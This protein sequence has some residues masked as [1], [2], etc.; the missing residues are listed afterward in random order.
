MAAS[1]GL[2]DAQWAHLRKVAR[3]PTE[4]PRSKETH[5][6]AYG[7]LEGIIFILK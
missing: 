3:E 6:C 5:K 1:L 7:I 2:R 4:V